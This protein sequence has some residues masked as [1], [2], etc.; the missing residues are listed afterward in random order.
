MNWKEFWG[1]LFQSAAEVE[2]APIAAA[3]EQAVAADLAEL[4]TPAQ[5]ARESEREQRLAELERQLA[6]Q[7]EREIQ[8]RAAAFAD[9]AIRNRQAMPAERESLISLYV[10]TAATEGGTAKLEAMVA[11]RPQHSLTEERVAQGAG[12]VLFQGNDPNVMT[13]ER[14][15]QLL[16]ATP[17]GQEILR[18]KSA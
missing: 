13:A 10:Q 3:I 11:A 7:Q 14:R 4:V 6:E 5:S 8:T 17:L 2:G 1:G 12:G 15:A 16:G 9:G 18:A